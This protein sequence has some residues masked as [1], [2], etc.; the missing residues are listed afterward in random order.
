MKKTFF[1]LVFVILFSTMLL[2][3]GWQKSGSIALNL[4]QNTYSDNW[5]GE[6]RSNVNWSVNLNTIFRRQLSEIMHNRNTVKLAFGQSHMQELDENGEKYWAKPTKSTDQIDLESMFRFTFGWEVDPFAALRFESQF[7][8]KLGG[9]ETKVV[10]PIT[11]TE[12][13][14]VARQIIKTERRE[15]T[16]RIGVAFKQLLEAREDDF[17][18]ATDGGLEFVAEFETPLLRDMVQYN[19]KLY[20]YQALYYS[21]ADDDPDDNWKA[22]DMNWEHVLSAKLIGMVNMNLYLQL[23]YDKQVIDEVRFEQNLGLSLSYQLF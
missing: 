13:F 1:L 8:D 12:S 2:A 3:E 16:T 20:L 5:V 11:I 23:L 22:L 19:T 18:D 10:N 21:E 4:S 17:I 15:L 14:G 7:I 6:E 9:E